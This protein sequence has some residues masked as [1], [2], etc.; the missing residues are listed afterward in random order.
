LG[1]EGRLPIIRGRTASFQ[2][3]FGHLTAG[4]FVGHARPLDLRSAR[5]WFPRDCRLASHS[6]AVPPA[7]FALLVWKASGD[8]K[9]GERS[10]PVAPRARTVRR[11][12]ATRAAATPKGHSG[13]RTSTD[14]IPPSSKRGGRSFG[15]ALSEVAIKPDLFGRPCDRPSHVTLPHRGLA[16]FRG[17]RQRFGARVMPYVGSDRWWLYRLAPLRCLGARYTR[18]RKNARDPLRPSPPTAPLLAVRSEPSQAI[19]NCLAGH[20]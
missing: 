10:D 4:A 6:V 20:A 9:S 8:P 1:R 14:L 11:E 7:C 17:W 12:P 18:P 19:R 3:A 5:A 16:G 15:A 13:T 2:L